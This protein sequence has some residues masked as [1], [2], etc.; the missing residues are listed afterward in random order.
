MG[1][2]ETIRKFKLQYARIY[3]F[4]YSFDSVI[5]KSRVNF[6]FRLQ[7]FLK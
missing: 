2:V 6:F 4:T 3:L 1:T 7:K 5:M